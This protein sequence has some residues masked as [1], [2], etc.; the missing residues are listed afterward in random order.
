MYS[1][2]ISTNLSNVNGLVFV[3]RDTKTILET[4]FKLFSILF[5]MISL[6]EIINYS[7]LFNP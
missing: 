4:L 6:I 3:G 2:Y 1:C 7:N 5:S